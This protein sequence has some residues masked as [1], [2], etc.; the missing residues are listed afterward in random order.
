M[1]N[2]KKIAF[3]LLVAVLAVGFS[4]FTSAKKVNYE[5]WHFK[6]G[7]M[8]ND[9]DQVSAYEAVTDPPQGCD[10][11]ENLPCILRVDTDNPSTPDLASYLASFPSD[12]AIAN[13]AFIKRSN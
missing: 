9:A 7:S 5:Y 4:A 10:E 8:L 1:K 13:A 12:A 2:L 6:T 3:G 11:E